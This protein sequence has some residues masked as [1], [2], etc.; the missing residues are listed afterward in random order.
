VKTH[1]DA[2]TLPEVLGNLSTT[3]LSVMKLIGFENS[4]VV[5]DTWMRAYAAPFSTRD[6]CIGAIE[7]PLDALLR[8]IVPYVKE[9]F[10]GIEHLTAKPAMLVVGLR[11]RAIAPEHQIADFRILFPS[12]PIVTLPNAGHFCQEDAPE[13]I[14][15]LI[16]QFLQLTH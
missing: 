1:H 9:G 14:V 11:D 6:E 16:Q 13:T 2:G 8:R 10:A 15:A 5:T 7:F 12:G 4:S 3:V